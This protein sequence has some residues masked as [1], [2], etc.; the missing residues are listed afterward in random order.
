M[1]S[2]ALEKASY[3]GYAL[4]GVTIALALVFFTSH[5]AS[6]IYQTLVI[7]IFAYVILFLPQALGAA[8]SS[9]L[10]VNPR[11]E[12]AARGLGKSSSSVLAWIT[13]PQILPG[14]SAG[15]ALVFL[16]AMKEL[17]ATL[18]LS[19]IG[20]DTLA[21][22]IWSASTEAFFARAAL[23]ALLLVAVSAVPVAFM[24]VKGRSIG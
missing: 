6:F 5:Y 13:V 1:V 12:E 18:L 21:T 24:V 10:Q 19:P 17:P 16:T 8:R 4:P 23:P 14:I 9:L 2:G 11:T 15:A 22:E 7:L 20:F 3:I